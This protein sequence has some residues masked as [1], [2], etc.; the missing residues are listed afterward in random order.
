L[1]SADVDGQPT[2]EGRHRDGVTL[3]ASLFIAR[4]NV[5]GGASSVFDPDGR[6]C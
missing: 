3:V 5:V 6:T 4:R 1:A 2:P